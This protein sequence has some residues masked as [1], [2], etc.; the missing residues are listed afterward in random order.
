[1][2]KIRKGLFLGFLGLSRWT[3][4]L[5]CLSVALLW[6]PRGFTQD[7]GVEGTEVAESEQSGAT[8]AEDEVS[9][10]SGL[11]DKA[12]EIEEQVAR[13]A[14]DQAGATRKSRAAAL[15]SPQNVTLDF[16]DADIKSVLRILALKSG[17]NIVTGD[18][19]EIF[20]WFHCCG[21]WRGAVRG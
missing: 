6:I 17:V 16:K 1:M 21:E 7:A 3:F 11:L 20:S 19:V 10:I 14:S 5:L 12:E 8:I 18:G 15:S 9:P 4:V 13:N 2:N